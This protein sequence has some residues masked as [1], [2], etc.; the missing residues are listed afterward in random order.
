MG[1]DRVVAVRAVGRTPSRGVGSLRAGVAAVTVAVAVGAA[2]ATAGAVSGSPTATTT[3]GRPAAGGEQCVDVY[4]LAVQ[5]TGQS[6]VGADRFS[7]TGFLGGL[8][9]TVAQQLSGSTPLGGSV[10]QARVTGESV[11]DAHRRARRQAGS[12]SAG[13]SSVT[14]VG[15][16][17]VWTSSSGVRFAREYIPYEASFGGLVGVGRGS[18]GDSVDGAKKELVRRGREVLEACPATK[19]ALVGYSQGADV[20]DQTAA[21]IGGGESS[22]GAESVGLVAV[23]GS[24]RRSAGLPTI[25][26]GSGVP[27]GVVDTS[28]STGGVA[29]LPTVTATAP[30]GA[31][32]LPAGDHIT[33]Y[34]RLTGRVANFCARG[35]LV[36][37]TPVD[38]ATGRALARV[39]SQTD[40]SGGDPF[41]ALEQMTDALALTPVRAVATGVNEDVRG[42]DLRTVSVDPSMSISKRIEQAAARPVTP[43]PG[44][45]EPATATAGRSASPT[46]GVGSAW[47]SSV[48]DAQAS[49]SVPEVSE[50]VGEPA[51]QAG[52]TSPAPGPASGAG[53]RSADSPRGASTLAVSGDKAVQ[54][55]QQ[56]LSAVM[57]LGLL[58]GSAVTAVARDVFTP[59][60][61]GQVAT[62]GLADP[63]A[64]LAVLGTK[65]IASATEVVAPV[66]MKLAGAAFDLARREVSDNA[67]LLQMATDVT[68]WNHFAN[69]TSYNR[70]P[71]DGQGDSA[72][73]YAAAWMVA[74]ADDVHGDASRGSDGGVS[75]SSEVV[76]TTLPA[77]T[78]AVEFGGG[79]R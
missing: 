52:V 55:A 8:F 9:G 20:V 26:G 70:V 60:M 18:Y 38:A 49:T 40:V 43:V 41:R 11:F 69:H 22:I 3:G 4:A 34:G 53:S 28:A 10:A 77:A 79:R 66:G 23:F 17:P 44:E 73:E 33:D 75:G 25:P 1:I 65:V 54:T 67:G 72:L 14:T 51:R 74:A 24:P 30:S 68:Y 61:I 63:A 37:D 59:E 45:D 48:T 6:S 19:L 36:C 76:A 35:D 64:G 39:V 31:G 57:K 13:G 12:G 27:D 78:S 62:A 42:Q 50:S 47:S 46:A 56:A 71:V 16:A 21:L 5:G 7:D 58:G 15:G 2:G 32:L 29:G